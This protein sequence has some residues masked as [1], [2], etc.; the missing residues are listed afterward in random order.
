MAHYDRHTCLR[1]RRE[2]Q[3]LWQA[4]MQVEMESL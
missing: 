3:K 4:Q 1:F 2:Q